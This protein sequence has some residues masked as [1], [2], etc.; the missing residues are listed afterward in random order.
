M[1]YPKQNVSCHGFVFVPDGPASLLIADKFWVAT[2]SVWPPE[3][4]D[5]P[6]TDMGNVR[7]RVGE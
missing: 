5:I 2:N 7:L 6:G 3:R 1:E 4:N